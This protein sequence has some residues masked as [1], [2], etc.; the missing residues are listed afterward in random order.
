MVRDHSDAILSSRFVRH[1]D[2]E[3][4]EQSLTINITDYRRIRA[5]NPP[6]TRSSGWE[7]KR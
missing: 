5:E 1:N 4:K 3:S 6:I 2:I 7:N